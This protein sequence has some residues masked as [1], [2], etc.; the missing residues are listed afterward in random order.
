MIFYLFFVFSIPSNVLPHGA[1]KE[2]NSWK[3]KSE[4]CTKKNTM[5]SLYSIYKVLGIK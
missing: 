3:L 4:K 1:T 5:I 2:E